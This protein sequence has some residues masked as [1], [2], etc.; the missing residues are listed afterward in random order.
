ML[1]ALVYLIY[2]MLK[3]KNYSLLGRVQME[4]DLLCDHL[5]PSGLN[6]NMVGDLEWLGS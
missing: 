1:P 6:I 2:G 4:L 3:L 5:Q